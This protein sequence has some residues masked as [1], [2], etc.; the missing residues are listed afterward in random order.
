MHAIWNLHVRKALHQFFQR[1]VSVNLFILNNL[2][3][4][5]MK[6]KYILKKRK[7][8]L[9]ACNPRQVKENKYIGMVH[10]AS[11]FHSLVVNQNTLDG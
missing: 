9:K 6:G 3:F 2:R 4:F 11:T 8:T 1:H 5:L 7:L 10:L